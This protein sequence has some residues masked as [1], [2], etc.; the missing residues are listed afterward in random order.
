MTLAQ[1]GGANTSAVDFGD[2]RGAAPSGL[3]WVMLMTYQDGRVYFLQA[4][5]DST[6]PVK[7]GWARDPLARLRELQTG[8]PTPLRLVTDF[9]GTRREEH[10]LHNVFSDD[11]LEG[12]WFRCSRDLKALM[13]A[14]K[15]SPY[16]SLLRLFAAQGDRAVHYAAVALT[17]KTEPSMRRLLA[18]TA[19]YVESDIQKSLQTWAALGRHD[20]ALDVTPEIVGSAV[21]AGSGR[22]SPGAGP[23][24]VCV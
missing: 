3:R 22:E 24:D 13:S 10:F 14:S 7:I 12:E 21:G 20:A 16:I 15:K 6:A 11:K 23:P 2:D 18:R 19:G 8:Y 1:Q 4:L 9:E 5:I 17:V